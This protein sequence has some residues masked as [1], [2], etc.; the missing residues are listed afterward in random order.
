MPVATFEPASS[1]QDPFH[2]DVPLPLRLKFFPLGFP[3]ELATNSEAVL[4]AAEQ[5]WGRFQ[6]AYPEA[7]VSIHLAVT[8]ECDGQMPSRPQF[9]THQHVMSIVS[10]AQNQV[11][12]DFGRH[13]AFGW[14]TARV[15]EE[16]EFLRLHFLESAAMSLVVQAYLAPFHSG[17]V[18]KNGVGIALCGESLAGKSTLS[19]ACA[20]SGWTFIA[21]DGTFL[22]RN[23][24]DRYAVGNPHILRLREDAKDLFPELADRRVALRMNGKWGMEVP[25]SELP[26]SKANGCSID[27]LVFLRRSS[28]GLASLKTMDP[29]DALAWLQQVVL[30]GPAEGQASQRQ[31]YRR[32]LDSGLWELHYSDLDEAVELLNQLGAKS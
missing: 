5:S 2:H 1:L 16:R 19:Y 4:A 12:C 21:D 28:G 18:T 13:C 11:I 7:P 3:V 14:L 20:R 10:D 6:M 31:A 25:T 24:E 26:F 15:T 29:Q 17:L 9:H 8:D 22:L 23:R 30:Y 27:H 32:L